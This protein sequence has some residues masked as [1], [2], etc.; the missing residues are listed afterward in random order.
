MPILPVL[1]LM[2]GQIVRGVAGRRE[3]YRPIVSKLVESA[4]PLSVAAAL[5]A[6]FGFT[7]YYLADLDAIQ[8]GRPNEA[9]YETLMSRGFRLWI[10][11]GLRRSSDAVLGGMLRQEMDVVVGLESIEGAAE[12]Q[13]I[14]ERVGVA[15]VVFSLDLKAGKPLGRVDLWPAADLWAIIDH[16]VHAIGVRRMIVLDL[17]KVGVGEGV[18]TEDL[19]G[20]FKKRYPC[21]ELTAGGGVRCIDDVARLAAMGVDHVLVASALHDGRISADDLKRH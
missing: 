4:Q 17:A 6:H 5:R 15:R 18:G 7:E 20:Q 9:M 11:A 13:R 3:N 16:A 21:V 19:C 10:D 1:D 2:E 8:H 14:V 12:L